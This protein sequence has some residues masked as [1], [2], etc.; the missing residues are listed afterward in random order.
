MGYTEQ[1][2]GGS[3][4]LGAVLTF[5][6]L[7]TRLLLA[8][9]STTILVGFQQQRWSIATVKINRVATYLRAGNYKSKL[10]FG[11]Q[12]AYKVKSILVSA[13]VKEFGIKIKSH[14]NFFLMD[15]VTLITYKCVLPRTLT[16]AG[17]MFISWFSQPDYRRLTLFLTN[18]FF[19]N[20]VGF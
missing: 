13:H 10:L 3:V 9:F 6:I 19:L 17:R 18:L 4:S 5:A 8:Y 16:M 1:P 2:S 20:I 11:C 12:S 14:A 7:I 15:A